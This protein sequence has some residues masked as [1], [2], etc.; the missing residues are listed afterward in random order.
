M[1]NATQFNST[2]NGDG[3]VIQ[4]QSLSGNIRL[5]QFK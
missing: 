5:A 4:I 2:F 1:I 3:A